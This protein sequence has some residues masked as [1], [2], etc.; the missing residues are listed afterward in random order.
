M[1][2]S[3]A[4]ANRPQANVELA[5]YADSAVRVFVTQ[6]DR[7]KRATP[8]RLSKGDIASGSPRSLCA[9][10][11]AYPGP[12]AQA[13]HSSPRRHPGE[14]RR[15]SPPLRGRLAVLRVDAAARRAPGDASQRAW[16]QVRRE[17]STG[18]GG[19]RATD[20]RP[21]RGDARGG[22][23]Q[24]PDASGEGGARSRRKTCRLV[25]PGG[26][27]CAPLASRTAQV[28]PLSSWLASRRCPN[29][30]GVLGHSPRAP[31]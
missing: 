14:A 2:A 24:A 4:R 12:C 26:L 28:G 1:P 13:P 27:I 10:G 25:T 29:R 11:L 15:L 21:H 8:G 19:G 18:R 20:A 5:K 6:T 3:S 17:P 30:S 22:A 9:G 23:D 31:V 7:P 16:Q